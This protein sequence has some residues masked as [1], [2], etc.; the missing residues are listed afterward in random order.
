MTLNC[1]VVILRMKVLQS[2]NINF[3]YFFSK[4]VIHFFLFLSILRDPEANKA[5]KESR[6]EEK[7]C[8]IICLD[9]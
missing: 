8:S 9:N 4:I 3:Y 1:Q 5:L 7:T 6:Y 2:Q